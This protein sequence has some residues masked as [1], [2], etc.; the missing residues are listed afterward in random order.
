VISGF[1]GVPEKGPR[2]D[3]Y[4]AAHLNL[5][6]AQLTLRRLREALGTCAQ[7]VAIS[8]KDA[9]AQYNLA[10][11]HALSG[12]T[13]EALDALANDLKLGDTDWEYLAADP[14]FE[15][16]RGDPRYRAILDEMKRKAG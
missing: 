15:S 11:A 5:C 7:L 16:L 2:L 8:P 1:G 9:G 6:D 3:L 12:H 14:W 4:V 10:G 13:K